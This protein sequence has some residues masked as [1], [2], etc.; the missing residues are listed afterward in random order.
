MCVDAA[1]CTD[2]VRRVDRQSDLTALLME[3]CHCNDKKILFLLDRYFS[4]QWIV[5]NRVVE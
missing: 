1:G 3:K 4:L 2:T 5:L